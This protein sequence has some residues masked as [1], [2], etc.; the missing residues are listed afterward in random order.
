[1][2][3][4]EQQLRSAPLHRAARRAAWALGLAVAVGAGAVGAEPT[5]E[6]VT[7]AVGSIPEEDLVVYEPED[8]EVAHTITVFTDVNCPYCQKLHEDLD[9]YLAQDVRVRYAAF[10]LSEASRRLMDRVWC[11]EDRQAALDRA[12][13]GAEP[14]AEPCDAS[15]VDAHMALGRRIGVRG[16][17]TMVMPDGRV[18]YRLTA[19]DLVSLLEQE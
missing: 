10:P 6:E 18:T 19:E 7:A 5:G 14:A 9:A 8:G 1:M 4:D 16:T 11:S 3:M 13:S 2:P 17:P 12:F 15:P